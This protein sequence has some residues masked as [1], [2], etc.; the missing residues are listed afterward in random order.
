MRLRYGLVCLKMLKFLYPPHS[1]F[2]HLHSTGRGIQGL[3]MSNLLCHAHCHPQLYETEARKL[4]TNVSTSEELKV[5]NSSC[6]N[7]VPG[8]QCQRRCS[9]YSNKAKCTSLF[10]ES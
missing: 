3:Q 4:N 10:R 7:T 9:Y 5:H 8:R 6:L 1:H 2:M